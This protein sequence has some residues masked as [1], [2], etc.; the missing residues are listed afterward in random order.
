MMNYFLAGNGADAQ[1]VS[2]WG[3]GFHVLFALAAAIGLILLI[4]WLVKNLKAQQLLVVAVVLTVIGLLGALLTARYHLEA[5][6]EVLGGNRFA[7]MGAGQFANVSPNSPFYP[8]QNQAFRQQMMGQYGYQNQNGQ[9]PQVQNVP[10]MMNFQTETQEAQT[11]P[12][13]PA[14]K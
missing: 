11:Q 3:L 2:L 8:Y 6:S 9:Q 5:M 4:V 10:F 13:T 14:K 12:K 7:Q 1:N